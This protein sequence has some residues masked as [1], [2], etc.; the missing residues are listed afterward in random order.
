MLRMEIF[1]SACSQVFA[2]EKST[3]GLK[4]RK[5][6]NIA[7][8]RVNFAR[9]RRS[10]SILSAHNRLIRACLRASVRIEIISLRQAQMFL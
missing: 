6:L 7:R 5:K 2:K 9:N 1:R 10:S 4:L 3:F 8:L